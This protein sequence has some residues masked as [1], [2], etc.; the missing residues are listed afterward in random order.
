MGR[1][2]QRPPIK[3]PGARE[4]E[5]RGG[6]ASLVS[7]EMWETTAR[8]AFDKREAS[9]LGKMNEPSR[10]S[11]GDQVASLSERASA[12]K[13][14][15][16]FVREG[17][18]LLHPSKPRLKIHSLPVAKKK[19]VRPNVLRVGRVSSRAPSVRRRTVCGSAAASPFRSS[20]TPFHGRRVQRSLPVTAVASAP[21]SP[22]RSR[23]RVAVQTETHPM[24]FLKMG[25]L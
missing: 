15:A 19:K 8:G 24:N 21:P 11:F 5:T 6:D 4:G 10:A 20:F 22:Y 12:G 2:G 13:R 17:P 1:S 7:V 9:T 25:L 23:D 16:S 3:P 18:A 14:R